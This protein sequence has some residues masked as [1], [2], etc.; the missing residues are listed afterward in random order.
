MVYVGLLLLYKLI[1][2]LSNVKVA[3]VIHDEMGY[4]A[5]YKSG[6]FFANWSVYDKK[7][8]PIDLK[9]DYLTHI[10]YSFLSVDETSGEVKFSDEWCD[11]QLPMVSPRDPNKK[12]EG[13]LQQL[14][15]MKQKNRNLKVIMSI[16]GWGTAHLFQA[17]MADESRFK[18]FVNTC[19]FFIE[20][21]G[22]D[23][24]D[25]DWEYPLAH[26]YGLVVKLLRELR[27]RMDTIS[28]RLSLS[29]CGSALEETINRFNL[30]DL[31]KYLSFWNL[32]CYDFAGQ[33]YSSKTGFHSNLY[34]KNG[35][36]GINTAD[37]VAKYL[38]LGIPANK[39]LLGMPLYGKQFHNVQ[40]GEIGQSFTNGSQAEETFNYNQ[41][42]KGH[43][44]FDS[45][46]VSASSYDSARK[47]FVTYDNENSAQMKADFTQQMGLG[48]GMWWDSS[49]DVYDND[50]K[51][52][53]VNY[54][55]QLGGPVV[56]ETSEN[57]LDIYGKS[58]YL[59]KL[60]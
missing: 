36:N 11:I 24:V 42:P 55:E 40:K 23:G 35:D 3:P 7:H 12:V 57:H 18:N 53:I 41:L 28:D 22:F 9:T 10:F 20:E 49:G 17:V 13:N 52:L 50:E 1:F 30:N 8:F 2:H 27:S 43:E 38:S 4:K 56:L 19:M 44:L 39:L 34:G 51:S 25:I 21:Y 26:E 48:G 45:T 32:M 31:D 5:G 29:Y 60:L 16:G 15:Q 6:V 58:K 46:K 37:V 54:I 59:R 33:G 14:F 47:L